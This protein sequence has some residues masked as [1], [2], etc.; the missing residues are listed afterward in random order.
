MKHPIRHD[1][2]DGYPPGKYRHSRMYLRG[3]YDTGANASD[4]V[5][6]VVG[7]KHYTNK[8]LHYLG[9]DGEYHR[10]IYSY[11]AIMLGI[12]EYKGEPESK[13]SLPE[14]A[15]MATDS[16][17]QDAS[18]LYPLIQYFAKVATQLRAH[19]QGNEFDNHPVIRV[20]LD[21]LVQLSSLGTTDLGNIIDAFDKCEQL[22]KG[23]S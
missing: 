12:V 15:A 5:R 8:T 17:Y 1:M 19:V 16:Y 2:H 13:P 14:I 23:I 22:K 4:V 6:I 21:K 20:M 10:Y 7:D 11:D 18:N 9:C 3:D